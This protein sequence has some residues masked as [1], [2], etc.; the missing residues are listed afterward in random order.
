MGQVGNQSVQGDVGRR[1]LLVEESCS[2]LAP[3]LF[4]QIKQALQAGVVGQ[5]GFFL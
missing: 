4:T 1:N 5:I 3:S 2:G